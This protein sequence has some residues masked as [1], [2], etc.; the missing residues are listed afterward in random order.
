MADLLIQPFDGQP[1]HLRPRSAILPWLAL[2]LLVPAP[3][4]GVFLAMAL[5]G[6]EGTNVGRIAWMVSKLWILAFPLAWM[7]WVERWRPEPAS[8]SSRAGGVIA[9]LGWGVAILSAILVFYWLFGRGMIDVAQVRSMAEKNGFLAP[10]KYFALAAYL[11]IINSLLE[12]Y[13][14]RWFVQRQCAAIVGS[15]AAVVLSALLFTI[16][17]VIALNA[18]M[19]LIATVLGSLGVFA[20]GVIWG[21]C[22]LRYRSIWPGWISH[23]LADVAVFMVGWH[24]LFRA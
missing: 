16:H 9:G 18:Q 24:I 4:I 17:H 2:S 8:F 6:A 3:T 15:A 13:V 21:A 19:G 10:W 22:A 12:E 23:I 5:D 7:L 14:W 1:R 11:S 20:G